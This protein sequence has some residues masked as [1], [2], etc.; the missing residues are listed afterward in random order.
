MSHVV[1][2]KGRYAELYESYRD[3]RG[4]P[5]KRFLKYLGKLGEID[6]EATLQGDPEDRA[7]AVAER[8]GVQVDA[9][10]A[11]VPQM[12]SGL[13]TGLHTGPVDPTPLEKDVVDTGSAVGAGLDNSESNEHEASENDNADTGG[14]GDGAVGHDGSVS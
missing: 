14:D 13:P 4:R 10:R 6:W 2:K 9:R 5:R 1:V 12:P 8:F 7:M 11:P 3:E